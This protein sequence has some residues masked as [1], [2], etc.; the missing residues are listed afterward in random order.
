VPWTADAEASLWFIEPVDEYAVTIDGFAAVNYPFAYTLPEGVKAYT[1]G[2]VI[3]VEGV[4]ALAISEY[5]GETVLP[6]TPLILA[7][8]TGEY[9]L[10]LVAVEAA[11]LPEG[12]ANTLKGTLK[13]AAVAGSDV[14]TLS[15]GAMKKRSAANGNVAANKAYYVGNGNADVLELSEVATGISNVV[16]DSENV[17]LYDLN[18]RE[19][20]A[21]VRG[22][23]VTSN[24]QKVLV[25]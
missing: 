16:T 5:K 3:T 18:G 12:Y 9:N 13:A 2:D 8:E 7:A 22:I 25:K 19:V 1:T 10:A 21:P 11:E 24:G 15:G 14:Y 17:K 23:Y 4:E 6:N 20:K